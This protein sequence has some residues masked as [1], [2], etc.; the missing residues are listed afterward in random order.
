MY[1]KLQLH[2]NGYGTFLLTYWISFLLLTKM[3]FAGYS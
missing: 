2:A 3:K 1:A